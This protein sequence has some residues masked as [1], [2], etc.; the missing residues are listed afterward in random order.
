[1]LSLGRFEGVARMR[2]GIMLSGFAG[3]VAWRFVHIALI[4]MLRSRLEVLFDWTLAIFYKR[5]VTRTD[6][7]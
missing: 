5:I 4:S 7:D 2:S 1:M 6:Y 3:W